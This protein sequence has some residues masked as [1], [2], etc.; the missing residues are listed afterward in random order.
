MVYHRW[1]LISAV[2][3]LLGRQI[4]LPFG[5]GLIYPNMYV[6]LMGDPGARKNTAMNIA[7]DMLLRLGY[8][9]FSPDR[10]SKEQFLISMLRGEL[11]EE[12]EDLKEIFLED[13]ACEMYIF[14]E[15]FTDFIGKNNTEFITMLC[16]LWD[17]PPHYDHPKIH[18]KSI[19]V[20]KPTTNILSGNTPQ[21]FAL[22]MPIESTGQ[23][24]GARSIY[25]HGEGKG[26]E[27]TLPPPPD[28]VYMASIDVLVGEIRKNVRGEM[29]IN[30]ANLPILTRMYKEY[31]NIE[32]YRF[33]YYNNR[34]FTH[35]LKLSMVLAA[36]RLSNI[37]EVEDIMAANTMLHYTEM[38]MP[39]ALGNFGKARN[40][41]IANAVIGI[42]KSAK[43][44][45]TIKYLWKQVA[46]DLNRIEELNEIVRNLQTAGKI[47]LIEVGGKQGYTTRFEKNG[48]W[49]ADLLWTEFLTPEEI[50]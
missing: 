37:I 16:K 45:C 44:P 38:K 49:Q 13:V 23:G 9:R 34:R 8:D 50:G 27:I 33:Q 17:C 4:Y 7:R 2:A 26:R 46:Q 30:L 28:K 25:V 12:A 47:Q 36:C 20:I 11:D 18:G 29:R 1:S 21:S 6:M 19:F 32:D 14:S 15:E 43:V 24:F 35:L 48:G 39:T 41:D 10:L 40:A 42:L 31:T 22:N 5:H 3:T